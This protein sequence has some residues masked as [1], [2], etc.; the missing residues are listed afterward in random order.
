[1]KCFIDPGGISS[2]LDPLGRFISSKDEPD[3]TLTISNVPRTPIIFILG[4]PGSGKI[5]HCDRAVQER[6]GLAHINMTDLIQQHVVGN[7]NFKT[8]IDMY[9]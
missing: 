3:E 2:E 9:F 6:Q 5:T 7:G 8:I 1:M 4:G